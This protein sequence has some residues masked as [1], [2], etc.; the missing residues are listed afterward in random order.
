M[1]ADFRDYKAAA[2]GPRLGA[3]CARDDGF[4]ADDGT[5]IGQGLRVERET[6]QHAE[7][8]RREVQG[9]RIA[10]T[11]WPSQLSGVC[12]EQVL[13]GRLDGAPRLVG[14][15]A[16]SGEVGDVVLV[17]P[18]LER[19]GRPRRCA[20]DHA[21]NQRRT[22]WFRGSEN[23]SYTGEKF[24]GSLGQCHFGIILQ[25]LSVGNGRKRYSTG[26]RTSKPMK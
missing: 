15:V 6:G 9:S 17:E 25:N 8:R 19:V 2:H 20:D 14:A 1:G 5:G 23:V 22:E 26:T 3:V 21:E 10:A 12:P 4:R 11:D 7:G 16:G 24:F 13:R 18:E